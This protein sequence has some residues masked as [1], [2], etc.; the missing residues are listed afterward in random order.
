M[1][2]SRCETATIADVGDWLLRLHDD[3]GRRGLAF[4]AIAVGSRPA[5]HARRHAARAYNECGRVRKNYRGTTS[6]TKNT[7][8]AD[9]RARRFSKCTLE[10]TDTW[11]KGVYYQKDANCG[12]NDLSHLAA[13]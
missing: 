11:F 12:E 2:S 10:G 7:E 1:R 6:P 9:P 3:R 5:S 13:A 8:P 4:R